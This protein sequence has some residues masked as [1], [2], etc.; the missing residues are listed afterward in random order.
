MRRFNQG[1]HAGCVDPELTTLDALPAEH[2]VGLFAQPRTYPARIRFR[3]RRHHQSDREKDVRGMSIK[4][5]NVD[6]PEPDARL[7]RRRTSS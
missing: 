6:G 7:R 2:R 5:M 4:V 3:L 1:R